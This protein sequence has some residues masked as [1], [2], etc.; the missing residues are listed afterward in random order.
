MLC[1]FCWWSLFK[2]EIIHYDELQIDNVIGFS[3]CHHSEYSCW[4]AS[5]NI[6]TPCECRHQNKQHTGKTTKKTPKLPAG[7]LLEQFTAEQ[8]M[9]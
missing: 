1:L 6:T 3:L 9:A 5:Y 4:F 2:K 8:D 7:G